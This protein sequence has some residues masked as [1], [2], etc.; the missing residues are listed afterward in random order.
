MH[1]SLL[2]AAEG[3]SSCVP[4]AQPCAPHAEKCKYLRQFLIFG[5]QVVKI[6]DA[7]SG[8]KEETLREV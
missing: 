4:G 1:Y 6:G 3:M 5:N 7:S 2:E 8:G